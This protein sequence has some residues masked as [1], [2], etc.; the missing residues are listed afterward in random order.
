MAKKRARKNNNKVLIAVAV[1]ILLILVAVT[2]VLYKTGR[3]DNFIDGI[4]EKQQQ[5]G[6]VNDKPSQD[7]NVS[8][9]DS[10]GVIDGSPI[11][12][13]FVSVGQGD[14]IVIELPGNEYMLV[15]AGSGATAYPSSTVK[16]GYYSYLSDVVEGD[17]IDYLV[18]THPDSDHVNMMSKVVDDYVVKNF[19]YNA[20]ENSSKTY[21][22]FTSKAAAEEGAALHVIETA[23]SSKFNV[24]AGGCLL[25]FYSPGNDGFTGT[26][27]KI[28]NG[29]S[30]MIML[31]Y[32]GR[33]LLL[34]GDATEEEEEWFVAYTE[35]KNTDVDFLKVAHHGSPYSST[36]EFLSHVSA[37]YAIISVDE[38]NNSYGHPSPDTLERL[39]NASATVYRTDIKG[40]IVLTI[41]S[42]GDYAFTFVE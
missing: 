33:K 35:Y 9:G 20:Y 19:Y 28:K 17:E 23:D 5:S 15:D 32:G 26:E 40:T 1:I 25:T 21:A 11:K 29:M 16:N 34:T 27:A 12:I 24:T 31:E 41:D 30:I 6:N 22:T 38:S 36:T 42:D 39:E 13:H 14:A 18:V 8:R 7:Q 37:E 10:Y 4:T 2:L 3:L